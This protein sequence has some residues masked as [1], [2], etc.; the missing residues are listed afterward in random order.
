MY[1]SGSTGLPKAVCLSHSAVTQA[2]LAHDRYIPQFSRFL[3]FA[4]PTFDVSV[5]EIFFPW[6]RGATLVSC[7]RKRL[8]S[9]LPGTITE[10]EIDAAELTP[11]VAASLVRHRAAVPTLKALLT[12]GEMLNA[13]VVREFGGSSDQPS[14]LQGMYGPTEA[15]IHCTL[16]PSFHSED[17][18]G[19]IGIPLDT[20]S[21]FV[22]KAA[23]PEAG[24]QPNDVHI[25]PRGEVGELAVGGHQLADG[26]LNRGEQTRAVFISH[27]KY[28]PL[29]RTGDKAR[30][31]ADGRLECLGRISSGQVKLRGQRIELGE[32]EQAASRVPD[33]RAVL[34]SVISGIL[35]IFCV[36]TSKSV[37]VKSVQDV[38]RKW[39]PEFMVPGDVVLL[40]DFPYLPSGK[41]DRKRLEKDY[42]ER[43]EGEET[44]QAAISENSSKILAVVREV[45]G[46]HVDAGTPLARAGLDSLRSIHLASEL[47]R[48]GIADIGAIDLL[49]AESVDGIDSLVRES[50]AKGQSLQRSDADMQEYCEQYRRALL[51]DPITSDMQHEIEDT[52]PCTPVQD[53]MLA[54]TSRNP[55]AYCNA[56]TLSI[57]KSSTARVQQAFTM[58]A[59]KHDILRS[60]FAVAHGRLSTHARIVWKQLASSQVEEVKDFHY[61]LELNNSSALL[62][63]LRVQIKPVGEDIKVLLQLHHSLYD[64]WSLEII[65][66]D[67][68]M[69][70]HG[71]ELHDRPSYR[72]V[73]AFHAQLASTEDAHASSVEF[74]RDYLTEAKPVPM[75]N[76]TGL[77]MPSASLAETDQMLVLDMKAVQQCCQRMGCS[78]HILFQSVF[79]YLL[80]LYTGTEDVIFGTVYSGRTLPVAGAEDIVGPMLSTLPSRV[81]VSETRTFKD[82]AR[83]IHTRNRDVMK[84]STVPLAEIKREC[85]VAPGQSL[86]D[87]IF[88]WQETSRKGYAKSDAVKLVRSE[89]FLEFTLTLE[90][91][92]LETG[93]F[94]KATFQPA[95][96]PREQVNLL[97]AQ[98]HS[99]V[100]CAIKEPEVSV[101]LLCRGLPPSQLSIANPSPVRYAM[102][103]G[104]PALIEAQAKEHPDRTAVAFAR[105]LDNSSADISTLSYR[106]LNERANQLAHCLLAR[107]V[108]PDELIC[109]CMEKSLDAYIAILAIVKTGAAYLPVVPETPANRLKQILDG[110]RVRI[111]LSDAETSGSIRSI[112]IC[113]VFDVTAE[114]V[115]KYSKLSPEVPLCPGNLFYAVFTSGT[116]GQPK[117]VLVTHE[118]LLGNLKALEEIYPVPEDSRL[119]QACSLAFD[120]SV[121]EI[122]FT[123]YKGMTLCTATKDVLFRDMERAIRQFAATHLSMTPTVAALVDPANVPSVQFIVTAGEAVTR[124]V[125]RTWAGKGLFQGYGPSETTNICTVNPSVRPDHSINNIGPPFPNVSAFVL[126]VSEE[127]RPVAAGGVGELCFGGQQVFRGYQGMPD[128][129]KAKII[130][131]PEYGRVYRS[132]DL[133]RLL[134]SGSILIEGR[135][136]DQRKI[137]GQRIEL[138]EVATCLLKSSAVKDCVVE[139][140][141]T[142]QQQEVL[143][144]F[145]VPIERANKEY[146]II[147]SDVDLRKTIDQLF[148][149]LADSLPA[150]M[151]P[152]ALIPITAVP[153]TSN[154]KAEKRRL[155]GDFANL[156]PGKLETYSQA[157]EAGGDTNVLGETERQVATAIAQTLDIP[158]EAVQRNASFFGL[159]LDSVSAIRV[160]KALKSQTGCQVDVSAILKR[161]SVARLAKLID[162]KQ[163]SD[164]AGKTGEVQ[165]GCLLDK[166]LPDSLKSSL[167]E[168]FKSYGRHVASIL[169]CTPLQEAMLSATSGG[170]SAA[171][172]N[173]TV[174]KL[175]GDPERMKRCWEKALQRHEILRTAFSATEET[176]H[177]FVQVVLES[178]VLPW[179]TS[180][181]AV[182]SVTELLDEASCDSDHAPPY[183]LTVYQSK[184]DTYL[185]LT[186]HHAL[187]DGNAMEVLLK[188]IE[189]IYQD[190]NLSP[191]VSFSPFLEYMFSVNAEEADGFFKE[192]LNKFIPKPFQ[193][194]HGTHL[195]TIASSGFAA[196]E[197]QLPFS[198]L[199]VDGF[200]KRHSFSLLAL[201][202][203]SWAKVL[204]LCLGYEDVCFGNVVSG[205][206]V[207]VNNIDNLVAPCFNTVPIRADLTRAKSNLDLVKLMQQA[208]V[209]VLPFQLTPLRRIQ[210]LSA[211]PG[212]R[213]FDSLLLLQ[214]GNRPLD[215]NLWTLEAETGD[216]NFPFICELAPVD[217]TFSLTLHYDQSVFG[218]GDVVQTIR[219]V[220]TAALSSCLR[221]PSSDVSDFL[222]FNTQHIAGCLQSSEEYMEAAQGGRS[223]PK[224]S[225]RGHDGS[226]T[227]LEIRN[228]FSALSGTPPERIHRD[229]T[230]HRIGLDSISA[231]QVATRLRKKGFDV[232]ASDVLE[233]PTASGLASVAESR[234]QTPE[235]RTPSFDFDGFDER[236]RG[237]IISHAKINAAD[238]KAI[239]PCTPL[240]AGMISQFFQSKGDQYFNHVF[241]ELDS[242]FEI[243]K[244]RSAWLAVVREH[245]MLRTGFTQLDDVNTP[246]AMITYK[247]GSV[248]GSWIELPDQEKEKWDQLACQDRVKD[249]V[250]HD[251]R[252]PAWRF[253]VIKL[254]GKQ[255]MQFS[256]HHALYDAETLRMMFA[257]LSKALRGDVLGHKQ[258]IDGALS[259]ILG[260]ASQRKEAQRDFWATQLK[261]VQV[262][263]FPNLHPVRV[264]QH[265]NVVAER[266]CST[267][268]SQ[269]EATCREGGL[270]MQAAGQ[271]AWAQIL[272]T[273]TG[274]PLVSFGV[275]TSGRSAPETATAP[276]PC[277]TTVPL[278]CDAT[279]DRADLMK[280]LMSFNARMLKYQFTPL[281]DIQRYAGYPNEALFDTIF[282]YQKPIGDNLTDT[283]WRIVRE[284]ATVDYG[285]SVE[286]EHLAGDKLGL[287][288]TYNNGQIPEQQ[289]ELI[290]KQ[291]ETLL[292]KT[293]LGEKAPSAGPSIISIVPPKDPEI[294][295]NVRTLHEFVEVATKQHPD[296]I[297]LEYVTAVQDSEVTSQRWT[298]AQ[299]D[300]EGN[301]VARLIQQHGVTPGNI[302]AMCFDK[303]PEASFAFLGILKA[304]CALLAI[305]PTAPAARKAFIL[306]DSKAPL[307]LSTTQILS[308]LKAHS[309]VVALDLTHPEVREVS[310]APVEVP[311]ISSSSVSYVLYTSGTTGTPKGCE[312][313]HDNAVQA[314]LAFERLFQGRYDDTSRWLQFASYHFDVAI[315]EHFWTWSVGMRLVVAPRDLVLQDLMGIID[316]MQITHIDLTPS[317]GRLL[318]PEMVPSLHRGVFITGGE[319]VKQEILDAW[320]RIG[321]LFNFYGPT[322]CTIGVTTFPSMPAIG[323]PSNIGWQFDNVGSLVLAPGT[324]QPV[325]R[326]GIGELCISGRLVGK[327]YL[328]RPD[329][330][331]DRFPYLEE[332]GERVYR[333]GDLVRLLHDNSFEFLG[334]IDTQ[335]KLRGQ[336]LE[337]DEIDVVIRK[338]EDVE[339]VVC[340]VTKHPKQQKDQLISFIAVSSK[341]RQGKPDLC[342]PQQTRSLID[343]AKAACEEHLPGYMVPTHFIP[344]EYIPLSVN[345]KVEEKILRALYQDIPVSVLQEYGGESGDRMPF[346]NSERTI[347]ETLASFLHIDVK[348]LHPESNVF[349]LGLSSISAIQLAQRLMKAGFMSARP[350]T[351]MMNPTIRR[352]SKALPAKSVGESGE[353]TAAK[354]TIAACR[355]RY[356]NIAA[357][358]LGLASGE[359]EAIAPCTPLQQGIIYRS[360]NS[361][362]PLY[363][364]SFR[365][366]LN[367]VNISKLRD[368]FQHALDNTQI[369]RTVFVETD[370]GHIQAVSHSAELRWHQLEVNNDTAAEDAFT[371]RKRT[372]QQSNHNA[373]T[374]LFELV[375]V[376]TPTETMLQVHIHH[377]LYDGNAWELLI[378]DVATWYRNGPAGQ[379]RPSFVEALPYGP[380]RHI[381]GAKQFWLDHLSGTG[382]ATMPSISDEPADKDTLF[383]TTIESIDAADEIRKRLN[384]TLHAVVQAAWFAVLR[385]YYS[386]PVGMVVSGRAI[387]FARAEEVIGP[388]FNTVPFN[389]R[390]DSTQPWSAFIRQCHEFNVAALPFQHTPLRDIAK[391]CKRSPS[392]PLFDTL[393]VFQAGQAQGGQAN[394]LFVPAENDAFQADYPL[395]FEAEDLSSG[396]LR[397]SIAAQG[398]ICNSKKAK[399]L[400][401]EFTDALSALTSN[402]EASISETISLAHS[403]DSQDISQPQTN[404]VNGHMNGRNSFEWTP[405]ALTLRQEIA[406][407]GNVGEDDVDA[408]TS[409]FQLGLD[410]VDAVKLSSRLKKRG[411]Q[412]P[413][414]VIMKAQTIRRILDAC[415]KK[416]Q[417]NAEHDDALQLASLE[418]RIATAVKQ[419]G[420]DMS[421][422][423]RV[424]PATPMQEALV[425]E[426]IGSAYRQY[427]NHDVLKLAAGTNMARLKKAWLTVI[428]SSPILRTGFLPIEDA[429]LDATFAQVVIKPGSSSVADI[430]LPSEESIDAY[431]ETVR[432][433][434][435]SMAPGAPALRV[436]SASIKNES[437]LILSIAH[438]LYD[439]FSLGL[440]HQ[441]V[442]DAYNGRYTPRPGYEAVLT[443]AL[444]T[445]DSD[446]DE[447]WRTLLASA[448]RSRF[449]QSQA[450]SRGE[451]TT[452]RE[453]LTSSISADRVATFC[454][455]QGITVQALCQTSWALTLAH[456]TKVLDVMFGVVL[457]GRD[458]PEAERVMFPTMNT[459]AMRSVIHG[460]R[461]EML[462][463]MQSTVADVMQYQQTPLRRIQATLPITS[464]G[465][466]ALFDTLFTY[467]KRP[468]VDTDQSALLYESVQGA[469]DVEYPVAVEAEIVDDQLV[470][471]TACKSNVFDESGTLKLL[472]QLDFV[473]SEIVSRPDLPSLGFA[474]NGV[475]ICDLP[476]FQ[477]RE[478]DAVTGAEATQATD[479]PQEE[480]STVELKIREVLAKVTKT[481]EHEVSKF[482]AIQNLGVDSINTIKISA[483][484]RK[485]SMLIPVSEILSAGTISA[486]ARRL[487]SERKT[488]ERLDSER[489]LS[490]IVQA[491]GF[492]AEKF[493]FDSTAVDSILPATAGQTYMLSTWQV[494][495][496]RLFFPEFEYGPQGNI[497]I[498]IVRE[499][500]AAVLAHHA[501]LRTVFVATQDSEMPF[502][503]VILREGPKSFVDASDTEANSGVLLQQP[504]VRL[505]AKQTSGS[506][507]LRLKIHHALYDAVSLPILLQDLERRCKGA[508]LQ[509]SR[510]TFSDFLALSQAE[511][512]RKKSKAFWTGYLTSAEP[513]TLRTIVDPQSP[514]IE[515]FDPQ[516]LS[517]SSQAE[518]IQRKHGIS[519]QAL[520]FAAYAKV[521][522]SMATNGPAQSV[523]IG[524]YLANRSH[525]DDLSS[526]AA[527]TINLLPLRINKPTETDL[528]TLARCIQGDI[529]TISKPENAAAGLWEIERW[530][531]VK[532]DTFVNFLKLPDQE[533][534]ESCGNEGVRIEEIENGRATE[535]RSLRHEA[536]GEAFEQPEELRPNPAKDAYKVRSLET[537]RDRAFTNGF[538]QLSLDIEATVVNGSLAVGVFGWEDMLGLEEVEGVVKELACVLRTAFEG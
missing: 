253:G 398:R 152:S 484:L 440:L 226:V 452:Y 129:T 141:L 507:Q 268:I 376:T 92:P 444:K 359:I 461:Q 216:M 489:L 101:E 265:S 297:A 365:Y 43:L 430:Q 177:P 76:L 23:D 73:V 28:G 468:S 204:S 74:W 464:S 248:D 175:F 54:E 361:S 517:L 16:Q 320:G 373:L 456:Y 223:G 215:S 423:E 488:A 300:A 147:P 482:T 178:Y 512:N 515:H 448:N 414:S 2:L 167:R 57:P 432:K 81:N 146:S 353:I 219:D 252:R 514:R 377:T 83:L 245:E 187:Y 64:Q 241:Y 523:I 127:F 336:R 163:T 328:N 60:G 462:R 109:I 197:V 90:V 148:T 437:Y 345:N 492:T 483:L 513:S 29:Y 126:A 71:Q 364:N 168:E 39:L 121:F 340:L 291:L 191:P 259:H 189:E 530:T 453:E 343:A 458:S 501:I 439:G 519:F 50:A 290:L 240:Q 352:L 15:A 279:L 151:V 420:M 66:D 98:M 229:T 243:R 389:A 34:A 51:N 25:L 498:S 49:S 356:L 449:P 455:K 316:T 394:K 138:G 256:A 220:F 335:V 56:I 298:Y 346:N 201:T 44:D 214:Q 139:V 465:S 321:S 322:E 518:A 284:S 249:S 149:D 110:G 93:V 165:R 289:A 236:H 522:A 412:V 120:V 41:A 140:L 288:L 463:Y 118:N 212:Q 162:Q 327:G 520:F 154:G 339:D 459:V 161:P 428:D 425:A 234:T 491:K 315:L 277:I 100:E 173:K 190:R 250:L 82:L 269:L 217:N 254:D 156:G 239:R 447:F 271:A 309:N 476:P 11:S 22:I 460:T 172:L 497:D 302:V 481:P 409:I 137:R 130:D 179:E 59:T 128:L 80:S 61:D 487:S 21:C 261:D 307:L 366:K 384:V 386:A 260:R 132:G 174:F 14:I 123:W 48:R 494:T 166:V 348:E 158:L 392:S 308:D 18:V 134:P 395:S 537:F 402:P 20:V 285:V 85:G 199:D 210:K 382:P 37:T 529:Q 323:K 443:K 46:D 385:K 311:E 142:Q 77:V 78:P 19:T 30:L 258:A 282:A 96:L 278:A 407:V 406:R 358:Q 207:P 230:I 400:A 378:E 198:Q 528:I 84:H 125:H 95:V 408:H 65:I 426:M 293:I 180:K 164:I 235:N 495:E 347:A 292:Y 31:R 319:A 9:D 192:R 47:R 391:W 113:K 1:T 27:P 205:R 94:A 97:L 89:D 262:T 454:R 26:Y 79:A 374:L 184:S 160:S 58:L 196:V 275:V 115:S 222:D 193:P 107:G 490:Q 314:L 287:R 264:S 38:C 203:A 143:V 7:D 68:S 24:V 150:Y 8:L 99:L 344:V 114:D 104:L 350:A 436:T 379:D 270:S 33:C 155:A 450:G 42:A 503:Q 431:F 62:R 470:W 69:L 263:R 404:G 367:D 413:V 135:I 475:S 75:P 383:V 445:M 479:S 380:L 478:D 183:R 208:N 341:R 111:C 40:D 527:P 281:T 477:Q 387:E 10:L 131:H 334:R 525:I 36:V 397:V 231:I 237:A 508:V 55:K 469:N 286:L 228:A 181:T 310:G 363:F 516:V 209:E 136:D 521:Y 536:T 325:L 266:I 145:W 324:Q 3:Q 473:F 342:A 532:V 485:E 381:G 306:Q 496:G 474:E 67:L 295:T 6:T 305:D 273:Y 493:G 17:S 480:W 354:Q 466:S 251:F 500:W 5:F 119:L 280:S 213:L 32:I 176:E 299:L 457:A 218:S 117:G 246:Y 87:C 526:V 416:T 294:P 434:I 170:T 368:A 296:R 63:P 401:K 153:M 375:L 355:Q 12:I 52:M 531:G 169:P 388:L 486:I 133:G 472:E 362:P 88:V 372:W 312:L 200:L 330:T 329:L 396:G 116:T 435:V 411:L 351:I 102:D 194:R 122:F 418:Q 313:T 410:S 499:A 415:P 232:S 105:S 405:E 35:V 510:N 369:L 433:E 112:E 188:E 186:M 438:A 317:L 276:F 337:V 255:C 471:R 221:Y 301:R 206:S 72:A 511:D 238:I 91:E 505:T 524:V 144:A 421:R 247:S 332:L 185:L 244:L 257:D 227:E 509:S 242:K 106:E 103:G 393:F 86:F 502:I 538:R 467:Q 108:L 417:Q 272:A 441:D 182:S 357:R 533:E 274:E 422:V 349:S 534:S 267:P 318:D 390:P 303:C 419:S 70:L 283:E 124:Q 429:E 202:Q 333:T 427:F 338:C 360:L 446:V 506:I 403:G 224:Q 195:D 304:G 399:E 13:Q 157:H 171:Y 4:S 233:N 225:E 45:L 371:H 504:L 451:T 326:G 370:E 159:G 211:V 424:L 331:N 53:A 442:N 535:K